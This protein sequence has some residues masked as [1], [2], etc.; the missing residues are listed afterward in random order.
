MKNEPLKTPHENKWNMRFHK[1]TAFVKIGCI[2][3]NRVVIEVEGMMRTAMAR[4][5]ETIG[6]AALCKD[7]FMDDASLGMLVCMIEPDYGMMQ[8]IDFNDF[9]LCAFEQEGYDAKIS[10]WN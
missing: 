3:N 8:A 6:E 9:L 10:G 4:I 1:R 5:A 2:E 7:V